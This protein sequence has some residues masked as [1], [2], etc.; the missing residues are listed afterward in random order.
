MK[1]AF[2]ALPYVSLQV[3]AKHANLDSP[4][5]VTQLLRRLVLL[6]FGRYL[7]RNDFEVPPFEMVTF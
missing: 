3:V 2:L 1:S 4:Y 5:V 7:A 6:L